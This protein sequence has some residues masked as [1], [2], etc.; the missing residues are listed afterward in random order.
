MLAYGSTS[1]PADPT[2]TICGRA[3]PI[4]LLVGLH[5]V[6]TKGFFQALEDWDSVHDSYRAISDNPSQQFPDW[7][8]DVGPGNKDRPGGRANLP[9]ASP[10]PTG[11]ST[12]RPASQTTTRSYVGGELGRGFV[13]FLEAL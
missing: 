11:G 7:Y 2:K 5:V 10:P 12:T 8:M 6:V 1:Y 13:T 3:I 4:R 9:L